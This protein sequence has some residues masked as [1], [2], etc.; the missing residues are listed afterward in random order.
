M[1]CPPAISVDSEK[2]GCVQARS[3]T[4][5]LLICLASAATCIARGTD[6]QLRQNGSLRR[7]QALPLRISSATG[8]ALLDHYAWYFVNADLHGWPVGSKEPNQFGLFDMYGNAWEWVNDRWVD[9]KDPG[10]ISSDTEDRA[11]IVTDDTPRMRRGGSWSYDL[12]T[13]RSVHRGSPG[14]IAPRTAKTALAFALRKR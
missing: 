4:A 13:T 1:R 11:R 8:V 10:A 2:A 12:E 6:C 9:Y 3:V 5:V 14:G 7:A